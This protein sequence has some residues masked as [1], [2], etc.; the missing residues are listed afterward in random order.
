MRMDE[1]ECILKH[2]LNTDRVPTTIYSVQNKLSLTAK[3]RIVSVTGQSHF[4][5]KC[6]CFKAVRMGAPCVHIVI[7]RSVRKEVLL[8]AGD[9]NGR[10]RLIQ[11]QVEF[12]MQSLKSDNGI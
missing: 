7:V 4:V 10:W 9:F 8:K 6:R 11:P 2:E 3:P 5:Y 12:A 1:Y